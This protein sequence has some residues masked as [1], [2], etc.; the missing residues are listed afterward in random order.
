M[1]EGGL[2]DEEI[3]DRVWMQKWNNLFIPEKVTLAVGSS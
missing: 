3:V 2:T 1:L